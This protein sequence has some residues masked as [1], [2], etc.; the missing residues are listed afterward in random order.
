MDLDKTIRILDNKEEPVRGHIVSKSDV[1]TCSLWKKDEV[2]FNP[3]KIIDEIEDYY[4]L[5]YYLKK[6][7]QGGSPPLPETW[8]SKKGLFGPALRVGQIGSELHLAHTKP[9]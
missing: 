5:I 3:R 9:S 1:W 2:S 8:V 6:K 4:Y 7:V